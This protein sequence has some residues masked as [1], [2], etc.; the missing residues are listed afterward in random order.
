MLRWH[1]KWQ[2]RGCYCHKNISW[3]KTVTRWRNSLALGHYRYDHLHLW[4]K[5]NPW[6]AEHI[7][8]VCVC[9]CF[10]HYFVIQIFNPPCFCLLFLSE[11]DL[12]VLPW[13]QVVPL[14]RN[15]WLPPQRACCDRWTRCVVSALQLFSINYNNLRLIWAAGTKAEIKT[16]H[17]E[18]FQIRG[19]AAF[20]FILIFKKLN[21]WYI[22]RIYRLQTQIFAVF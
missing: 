9:L 11:L 13:L 10:L 5:T 15:P 18:E 21:D 12:F 6:T 4:Q 1:Q 14:Q 2:D 16:T 7:K 20:V 22:L 19:F 3:G 8:H 17:E